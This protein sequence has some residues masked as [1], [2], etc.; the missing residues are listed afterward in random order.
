MN[1][2]VYNYN[3]DL[4]QKDHDDTGSITFVMNKYKLS[5]KVIETAIN[6]GLFKKNIK[7]HKHSEETKRKLSEIRIKYLKNNPNKHFW[8]TKEKYKSKP[9]EYLKDFLRN[10]KISFVEEY[11]SF[12][13]NY[14]IDIAFPNEK[15][16][17]EI[18]GNQHYNKDGSLRKYYK[19][20]EEYLVNIGWT[21]KQI[22][23]SLVYNDEYRKKLLQFIHDKV[24][25]DYSFYIKE[26]MTCKICGKEIKDGQKICNSCKIK[27]NKQN[28]FNERVE[29]IINSKVN[30]KKFGWGVQISK[31]LNMTSQASIRW[32]KKNM[33]DFYEKECVKSKNSKL[34]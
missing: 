22:H 12:G 1:I 11:S 24:D 9:C 33:K 25:F 14:S 31:I 21:L 23:Y 8:K 3:W 15:I 13:R 32:I 29:K 17:L 28:K 19:E 30:F 6:Y 26:R 7:R 5:R 18:N 10:N 16:G 2:K 4:I 20:R 27:E 34:N